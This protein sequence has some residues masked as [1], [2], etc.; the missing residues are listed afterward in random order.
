MIV[1]LGWM[2]QLCK[3]EFNT[4]H[5]VMK[6]NILFFILILLLVAAGSLLA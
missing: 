6:S 4:I 3:I 2:L 5:E 1:A